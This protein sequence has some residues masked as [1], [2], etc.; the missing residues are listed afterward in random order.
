MVKILQ[1]FVGKNQE[2]PKT[3]KDVAMILRVCSKSAVERLMIWKISDIFYT[4]WSQL[5]RQIQNI[6]VKSKNSS[7]T[8]TFNFVSADTFDNSIPSFNAPC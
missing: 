5:T 2:M 4:E 1:A 3:K 6:S 8:S 7:R